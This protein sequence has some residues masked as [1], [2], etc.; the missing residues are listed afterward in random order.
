[1]ARSLVSSLLSQWLMAGDR[2]WGAGCCPEGCPTAF[3]AKPHMKARNRTCLH[4]R[5]IST[6][7]RLIMSLIFPPR[8]KLSAVVAYD[9]ENNPNQ[10]DLPAGQ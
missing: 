7:E 5:F 9:Q 6:A 10:L 1:M 8:L 4:G 3:R 2:E